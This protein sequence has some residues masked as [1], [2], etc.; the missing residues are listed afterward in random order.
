MRIGN[1]FSSCIGLFLA[2]ALFAPPAFA[3]DPLAFTKF[4]GFQLGKNTLSDV[5]KSLGTTPVVSNAKGSEATDS[6]F[7]VTPDGSIVIDFWSGEPGGDKKTLS[8][9]TVHKGDHFGMKNGKT[10]QLANP[11]DVNLVQGIQFGMS[12]KSFND[13]FADGIQS[14]ETFD[15]PA[16]TK[17]SQFTAVILT[18]KVKVLNKE[19]NQT[20]A[21]DDTIHI[22]AKFDEGGLYSLNVSKVLQ[23]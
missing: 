19:T 20:V 22:I 4:L 6:L 10:F 18:G 1:G 3:F 14:S 11:L 8:G 16:I 17:V 7:F 9:F 2:C 12:Q 5:Q 23:N 15:P 21:C 13:L